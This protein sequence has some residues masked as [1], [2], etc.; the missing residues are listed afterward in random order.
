VFKTEQTRLPE[1][2]SIDM[3]CRFLE[4]DHDLGEDAERP[5]LS[6]SNSST[7]GGGKGR[8]DIGFVNSSLWLWGRLFF[9]LL[10]LLSQP[11]MFVNPFL[12]FCSGKKRA[13]VARPMVQPR[14]FANSSAA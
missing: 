6:L 13:E 12:S 14:H 5:R 9:G 3:W 10:G 8:P 4:T 2:C 11:V 7:P 1:Y